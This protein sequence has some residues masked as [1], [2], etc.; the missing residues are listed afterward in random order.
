M[1]CTI[2][3]TKML[4]GARKNV[5]QD[6]KFLKPQILPFISSTHFGIFSLIYIEISQETEY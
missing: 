5:Y 4:L 6:F 2:M 1:R 3:Y